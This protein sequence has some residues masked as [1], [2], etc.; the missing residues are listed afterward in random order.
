[1]NIL[2][3]TTVLPSRKTGGEIATEAFIRGLENCGCKITVLGYQ[4]NLSE[5]SDI[6]NYLPV[7]I[8]HIETSSSKIYAARWL[9]QAFVK[10]IPY[11][12]QKFHS[13]EY[14]DKIR[15][16]LSQNTYSAIVLEHSQM[17]WLRDYIPSSYPLVFNTQNIENEIYTDH[18][19]DSGGLRKFIYKR[20]AALMRRMEG[21]LALASHQIWT[22]TNH[23]HDYFAEIAG[24]NK[25]RSFG[26]PS[27]QTDSTTIARDISKT[28][29]VGII[30]TWTWQANHKGLVWFFEKV[31]PLLPIELSI[32]VAGKGADWL[33]GKYSNVEY[34]GFVPSSEE[35]MASAR[36]IAIP[37]V[38]GGGIQIKTL[39]AI[40][41][42]ASVVATSFAMR[43]ISKYPEDVV[44]ADNAEAFS[45]SILLIKS[46]GSLNS[47]S[48]FRDWSENRR[49]A[50]QCELCNAVTD[51]LKIAPK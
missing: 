43:G 34:C 33:L 2:Y 23:D 29:D 15:M 36:V 49:Y 42:G 17:A 32:R 27:L 48:G 16:L 44:I 7:G 21:Q 3:L 5:T 20:E 19:N 31:Y 4:R 37:A 25:V 9:I 12:V 40:S 14:I 10:Q 46:R 51:L 24:A 1:V 35:F 50:F 47:S 13:Q 6:S 8:R 11:S 45:R 38:S 39:D 30:G 28:Y 22:L 18:A 26:V 41:S